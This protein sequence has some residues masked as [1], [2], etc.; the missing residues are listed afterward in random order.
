MHSNRGR[1]VA[2]AL[3]VVAIVCPCAIALNP[4]LDINQYAHTAWKHNEQISKGIIFSVAQTPDGYLWLGTEF[5]LLR[6]DG[7]RATPWQ[8]PGGDPLPSSEVRTLRVARDGR[9]WIGTR[10]GLASWKEGKLTHY[11][12]LDG[13]EIQALQEDREGAI[14]VGGW[15]INAGKL[16]TIQSGRTEC[17]GEDGRFGSG[18]TAL[19]ED[20]RGNLWAGGETSLWRWKPG[21]PK[22]YRIS[23]AANLI[24]AL[25]ESNDGGILIARHDGIIKLKNESAAPYPLPPGLNMRPQ[26]LFRDRDGGLWIGA[27]IDKGLLHIHEGRTDMFG[28]AEGLSGGSISCIFQDREG[29]VWVSTGDGLDRFREFA[30]PTFSVQQGLASHGIAAVLAATDR[31]LWV[32]TSH[33]LNRWDRGQITVYRKRSENGAP[34]NLPAGGA[35]ARTGTQA[36]GT[37]REIID[38][39][40]P[41]DF[42]ATL[43][44]DSAGKIWVGTGAG[45]SY[46]QSGRFFPIVSMPRGIVLSMTADP[47]GNVWLSH[48]DGFFRLFGGRLSERVPWAKLGRKEAAN[49]LLYDAVQG[50]LW[51]GFLDGGVGFFKD[52]QL[53]ASYGEAEGL[54][55]GAVY[56]L[57]VDGTGALWAA[58]DGGLSR[59]KDGRVLTLTSENGLPCN[60][61]HWMMEDNAHSVWLNL[62]CGLV[63]IARS[64]LEAWVSHPKQTIRATV[65]DNSDGVSSHRLHGGYNAVVTK[66]AD[67]RIWFVPFGGVS[68]IDPHHLPFNN[69]PP[70]VHIE[71]IIA[72]DKSYDVTNG[73]HLPARVH[74]LAIDYTALTLVVPEKVRFRVKLEGQDKNWRDLV[75]VRHAEYTNL[76]PKHYRFHVLACNN[77]GVWN[78]EGATLDFMIPPAWY[79]TNWFRALCAATFLAMLWAAYQLRVRQLAAQF[80]MRLEE[81]V[82]ERTRIARDLHDTLLQSF[83]ALLIRFQ[84]GINMLAQRPADARNVLE[85]AVHRASQAIAEGRDAIGGLRMST[86]EKNDLA[87][88]IKTI[89]EELA[90]AQ[91]N[92]ASTP[93][94]VLVEGTSR[95]LHPIL[96]DE[97]YRLVTEALRNCFRHAA[98][99]IVE[100]EIRYDE[101]YFRV[102]VRDDGKGIPSDVLRG[103]GRE[104]H[105]GLHGMRERAKLV[106]GKLT[107][108]TELDSGTEIEL[109]IPGARAYVKSARPFWSFGKR[110]ATETDKKET[111]ERE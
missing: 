81:R 96:R 29:T 39:G 58:T 53:R 44:Q 2:L 7:V 91:D 26:K 22:S 31:S 5:G 35:T 55:R 65:F 101:K 37:A 103:D 10:S 41:E 24:F 102:R 62:A 56:G 43:F 40:M 64:E 92:Q 14:W 45:L 30:V 54:A 99:E 32:G 42:I 50:G 89:A 60:T 105:Y 6:F 63:R 78:E 73:M 12:E 3:C 95:E 68:V 77:S 59:I 46:F 51:L 84:A 100:V 52:N 57:S 110:S 111:I 104:G 16:C 80:N 61:V 69:V 93:F 90:E 9:L 79:Q 33:G 1:Y 17:Y 72:D 21:P 13:H 94:Q 27:A 75:N 15:K 67:G 83:Q 4:S 107:I 85:D 28:P 97:V 76:P 36:S 87:V 82:G 49:A 11:P 98:A 66:S 18:V 109:L 88:A 74:D 38:T 19:Y 108:W 48:R 70:P 106:G 23:D 71:R 25:I 86:V 20:S 34:G 47:A 8:P